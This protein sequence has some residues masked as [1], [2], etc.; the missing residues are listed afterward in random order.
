[1]IVITWSFIVYG[2]GSNDKLSIFNEPHH[3]YDRDD[4]FCRW[5]CGG[6]WQRGGESEGREV[7]WQ[8]LCWW[9]LLMNI[10]VCQKEICLSYDA[11]N[12][13]ADDDDDDDD[14]NN[15]NNNNNM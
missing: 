15:N 13:D 5:L 14:N 12:V 3:Y 7:Q 9:S 6:V 4:I 2:R 8:G 11:D 10:S 1:M